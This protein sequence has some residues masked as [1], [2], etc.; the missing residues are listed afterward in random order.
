MARDIH[1]IPRTDVQQPL[2]YFPMQRRINTGLRRD[3]MITPLLGEPA[4]DRTP[5][6]TGQKRGTP[7]PWGGSCESKNKSPVAEG[8][9]HPAEG[10]GER[11]SNKDNAVQTKS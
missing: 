2:E 3:I 1:E 6:K 10:Y 4:T 9:K 8:T 7:V 11:S 5:S